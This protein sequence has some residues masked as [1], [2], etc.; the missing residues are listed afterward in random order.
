MSIKR[1]L[2]D[3]EDSED[4]SVKVK[5]YNPDFRATLVTPDGKEFE[6]GNLP[7]HPQYN[8][9]IM[10]NSIPELSEDHYLREW[11]GEG[12][13]RPLNV[14]PKGWE[15]F[16][17]VSAQLTDGSVM[18]RPEFT[19][20]TIEEVYRPELLPPDGVILYPVE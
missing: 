9:L 6:W 8:R 14:M 10:D 5:K 3:P 7:F 13:K 20:M 1:S 2:T 12:T 18:N 11:M 4:E 15:D 19:T 17:V 16:N